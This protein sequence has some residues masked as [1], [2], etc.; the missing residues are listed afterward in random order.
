MTA[1]T[2]YFRTLRLTFELEVAERELGQLL[3]EGGIDIATYR[4]H[5]EEAEAAFEADRRDLFRERHT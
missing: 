5:A 2:L 4:K 3:R 1:M